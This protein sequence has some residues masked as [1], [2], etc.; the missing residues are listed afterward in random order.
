MKLS[1]LKK[2]RL[3]EFLIIGVV[4]GV[5]EDLLAVY[6]ATGEKIDFHIFWIVFLVALPFAV[7]SE[8]VV[9]HPRFWEKIWPHKENGDSQKGGNNSGAPIK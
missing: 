7:I 9:D 8:L 5:A 6:F 3:V 1:R 2:L 4:M